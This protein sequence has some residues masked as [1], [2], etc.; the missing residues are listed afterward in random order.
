MGAVNTNVLETNQVLAFG[1]VLGDFGR[2]PVPVVK[3][4]S[5]RGE[6][7][8]VADT[9]LIDL[10]PVARAI[11]NHDAS[12]WSLGHVHQTWTR[13]LKLGTDG[14]LG[15]DL[16]TSVDSQNLG[17]ASGRE[18]A[19]VA[20]SVRAM[21]SHCL[22]TARGLQWRFCSFKAGERFELLQCTRRSPV[23]ELLLLGG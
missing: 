1:C 19:L 2:N 21:A 11:I 13:M 14:Q 4:S 10:R 3:T 20:T 22:E 6:F 17:L 12:S 16:V 15:A 8:T 9:L 5:G 7:T 18:S 23:D